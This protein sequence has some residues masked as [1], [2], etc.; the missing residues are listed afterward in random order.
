[1]YK[2]STSLIYFCR[3]GKRFLYKIIELE[4]ACCL[5]LSFLFFFTIYIM[6]ALV[7]FSLSSHLKNIC[8]GSKIFSD[9]SK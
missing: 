7:H 5:F 1:M 9:P 3:S 6:E 2:N 8:Y 4:S